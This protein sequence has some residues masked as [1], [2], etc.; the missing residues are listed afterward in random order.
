MG[1]L[2]TRGGCRARRRRSMDD[3]SQL[4]TSTGTRR[5]ADCGPRSTGGRL[6]SAPRPGRERIVCGCLAACLASVLLQACAD[7][8]ATTEGGVC[9]YEPTPPAFAVCDDAARAACAAWQM[10]ITPLGHTPL[11][12]PD[13][14]DLHCVVGGFCGMGFCHSAEICVEN[15]A[16]ANSMCLCAVPPH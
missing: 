3:S 5:G 13:C 6:R 9:D 16:R 11:Y 14:V 15:G 10:S 1:G 4:N 7:T 8:H 2:A 12:A